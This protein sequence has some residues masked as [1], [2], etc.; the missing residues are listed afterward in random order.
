VNPLAKP[1]SFVLLTIAFLFHADTSFA[2]KHVVDSLLH[3]VRIDHPDTTKQDHLNRLARA[4]VNTGAYDSAMFFVNSAMAL[5]DSLSSMNKTK[6]KTDLAIRKGIALSDNITGVVYDDQG[7]YAQALQ[8]YFTSLELRKKIDVDYPDDAGNKKGE[9][10]TYNNIGNVDDDQGN[11]PDAL[12]NYFA[13]LT[14]KESIGDQKGIADTYNNIGVVYKHQQNYSESLRNYSLA[15]DIRRK[16]GDKKGIADCYN[17]IGIVYDVERNFSAALTNL[18]TS[19]QMRKD[20]GDRAGIETCYSNIG[21]V[22]N[23]LGNYPEALKNHF[24]SLNI[25]LEI[26]DQAGEALSYLN[27]GSIYRKQKKFKLSQDFL[28]K[29]ETLSKNIGFRECLKND[30]NELSQLDSTMGDLKGA[31]EHYLLMVL[32]R[33]SLSNEV[34]TK[35][36]TQIEMQYQ[37]N[38]QHAADSLETLERNKQD[39]LKRQQEIRQQETYTYGG[40]AGSVLMLIVAIISIRAFRNKQKANHIISRQKELVEEKQKEILDSIHYARRIQQSLLPTEKYIS[41][42]I[43]D[44]KR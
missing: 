9:A 29:A 5:G 17:N 25:R 23:E 13:S 21:D 39:D 35:K 34:N 41:R 24:A 31:F 36:Q 30:Y 28:L 26:G 44:Q 1:F 14:I 27:I 40:I 12:K 16:I 32:Y 3:L 2:Q 8:H 43:P 42:Y 18:D 7:N 33:D 37:F 4:Y 15:L 11:Y 6:G 22:F 20:L 19:L 10:S 38:K